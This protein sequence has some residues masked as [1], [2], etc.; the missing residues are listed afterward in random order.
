MHHTEC[1]LASGLAEDPPFRLPDAVPDRFDLDS[2]LEEPGV[3]WSIAKIAQRSAR[4][5]Y[6]VAA[7]DR[8]V[9]QAAATTQEVRAAAIPRFD[10]NARYTRLS[11]IDNAPLA[12][13]PVDFD[14][15][16]AA[17]SQ[18][19][20]PNAQALWQQQIDVLEGISQG[21]I[22]I[23]QNQYNFRAAVRY[24]LLALFVEILPGIRTAQNAETASRYESNVARNDTALELIGIYM[25][26]ARARGA[27]AVAELA[28]QQA[29]ANRAQ[30][31]A[32]LQGGV[33]NRPDVARFE[34]RVASAQR[35]VA[36]SRADVESTA[37]ALRALLDIEGT[38]PLAFE[39]RLTE[40]P[41]P[42]FE[43]STQ[44]MVEAA[45]KLRDEMQAVN[46]LVRVRGIGERTV[47]R[48][49]HAAVA[50]KGG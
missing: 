49:R 24:P 7:A 40:V 17:A 3:P 33:G 16:R 19:I 11:P 2:V 46:A 31:E 12:P 25:D 44:D 14:Q 4:T 1:V 43:E 47:E 18:V 41:E 6:L 27:L 10:F 50:G 39:E 29:E 20:D 9:D 32:R 37:N 26:H 22:Q 15:A 48:L 30:A 34:A 36:E 38:G 23:P 8:R 35:G 5:V 28:L 21:T 13:I 42:A 45:W